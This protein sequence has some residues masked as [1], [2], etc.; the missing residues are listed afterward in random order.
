M[1]GNLQWTTLTGSTQYLARP[2]TAT[3]TH[4]IDKIYLWVRRRGTPTANIT[5]ELCTDSAGEPDTVLQ[6]ATASTSNIT[7]TISVLYAFDITNQEVTVAG[8]PYNIKVYGDDADNST[9]YWQV[10][11]QDASSTTLSSSD[12]S[13]WTDPASM[14]LYYRAVDD[15]SWRRS[16][17]FEYKGALYCVTNPDSTSPQ[18]WINGDRGVAT[19][20]GQ[21]TTGLGD[22]TKS[23]TTD[24]WANAVFVAWKG[25]SS[26]YG[27]NYGPITSNTGTVLTLTRPLALSPAADDTEYIIMGSSKWTER[28]T[29]GL[30][31]PVTDIAV[32]DEYVF[33]AQGEG[34]DVR[35]MREYNKN[36]VWT[37]EYRDDVGT[38][39]KF[40]KI[41]RDPVKGEIIWK[42]NNID[43][44]D[45]VS[46]SSSV[47][48]PWTK[49]L[50]FPRLIDDCEAAWTASANVTATLDQEDYKAGKGSAKLAIAA[51]F[52][53]GLAAYEDVEGKT[54]AVVNLRQ[55]NRVRMWIKSSIDQNEGDLELRLS[56][57]NNAS[58]EDVTDLIIPEL[59]AGRW[60]RV[61]MKFPADVDKKNIEAVGLVVATDN[62]ACN[63]FLDAIEGLPKNSKGTTIE[64][65]DNINRITGLEAYGEPE[66]LWVLREGSIGNV[67]NG[68]YDE[69]PLREMRNVRSRFNGRASLVHGVYLYFSLLHGVQ[70]YFRSNLDDVGPN[71]DLGLPLLYQGPIADMVGYPGKFYAAIDCRNTRY[72]S[73][74][75]SRGHSDWHPVYACDELGQHIQSLY[76]QSVPGWIVDRLWFS[77]GAD[78]VWLPLPG[79]TLREDTDTSYDFTHEAVV[80]SAWIYQGMQDL[81]KFFKSF[82]AF[83]TNTS[84]TVRIIEMDYM[85]DG[86]TTWTAI[87]GNINTEP[88]EELDLSSATPPSSAGKRVK[89]RLRIMT[90]DRNQ[91]VKTR[92]VVTKSVARIPIKYTYSW[93][94]RAYDEAIDIEGEDDSVYTAVETMMTQLDTW[95]NA[96][97][98]LTMR[99]LYS[100]FDNKTVQVDPA[101][102]AG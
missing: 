60:H 97:T 80:E 5:V 89:Y 24:E 20:A 63:V 2:F 13:T 75:M 6:T 88:S 92:A 93:T 65:G 47:V 44:A 11:T 27:R 87:S 4:D 1:P 10:G 36:S 52:T 77:Q 96:G 70:R 90:N 18:L 72:S 8:S 35:R 3:S 33:F 39:A 94:F 42:A 17:F 86:N 76:I 34:V 45:T 95:A 74:M 91:P 71:R 98:A 46:V 59:N 37:V 54:S 9:N 82:T 79:N 14:E 19:G 29:T 26:Q 68:V 31:G 85:L 22:S 57:S 43:N 62:G 102:R 15:S 64:L 51:G 61:T 78:I 58:T 38:K 7:D 69:V 67:E 73:I 81:T 48:T 101:R 99:C 30:T 25:A 23:W 21:G 12:G 28:G 84:G 32:A 40:L 50:Y 56:V 53:T 83:A 55:C 16:I 100:P 66:T 41:I 49:H